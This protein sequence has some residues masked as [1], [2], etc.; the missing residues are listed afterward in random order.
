MILDLLH[1]RLG[2]PQIFAS[3]WLVPA[4]R[5]ITVR[6]NQS[7]GCCEPKRPTTNKS[8]MMFSLCWPLAWLC[9]AVLSECNQ[10]LFR[11]EGTTVLHVTA[12]NTHAMIAV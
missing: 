5:R 12:P 10:S 2:L 8:R 11:K 9:S 7:E 1:Q 3:A 4:R 6:A